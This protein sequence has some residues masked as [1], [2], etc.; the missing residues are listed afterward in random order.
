[1]FANLR[2]DLG[3]AGWCAHRLPEVAL[4]ESSIRHY[5]FP[6]YGHTGQQQP[7]TRRELIAGEA[8]IHVARSTGVIGIN[9]GRRHAVGLGVLLAASATAAAAESD[10]LPTAA[11]GAATASA[12]PISADIDGPTAGWRYHGLGTWADEARV[13]YPTP[14]IDR[15]AQRGRTL[16]QGRLRG[17]DASRRAQTLAVNGNPLPLYA[18]AEGRFA[19]P[20]A[21]G[22]GSNSVAVSSADGVALRKVQFYEANALRTPARI[23]IVLGWDDPGAEVDLHVLTPDG[24]HAYWADPVMSNGGGLDVDSVDGPGPEVFTMTAPLRGSYAIYINYWGNLGAGGYN[25]DAGSNDKPMITTQVTLVFDENTVNEKRENFV[26]PLRAIG[27]L[28][29]IKSFRY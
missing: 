15:G 28:Q 29:L 16:I 5:F 26:V 18:D 20:Y 7:A 12:V 4:H 14:P 13:A 11:G 9:A 1:M 10:A 25:F 8:G 2:V 24:Q 6:R 23:R 22:A 17:I 27:D 21:F 3:E 19:R